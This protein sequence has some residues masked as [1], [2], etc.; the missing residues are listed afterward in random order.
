VTEQNVDLAILV[1]TMQMVIAS[2][3]FLA[4]LDLWRDNAKFVRNQRI[5]IQSTTVS[6]VTLVTA[7]L[8]MIVF[9]KFTK[10]VVL[11]FL[12]FIRRRG[13]GNT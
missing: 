3:N 11:Q 6:N 5:E 8:E 12:P 9:P 2:L 7:S 1:G 4:L 13:E 10:K